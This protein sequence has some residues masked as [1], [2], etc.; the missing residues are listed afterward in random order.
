MRR[1]KH[2]HHPDI[3]RERRRAERLAERRWGPA[4]TP[5]PAESPATA[6]LTIDAMQAL[7]DRITDSCLSLDD[8]YGNPAGTLSYSGITASVAPRR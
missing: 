5:Y 7:F 6:T 1:P 8:F 3:W 4:F 2:R